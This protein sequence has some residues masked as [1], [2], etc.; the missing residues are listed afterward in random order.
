MVKL[1]NLFDFDER[2]GRKTTY[3]VMFLLTT[4]L[5]AAYVEGQ[6]CSLSAMKEHALNACDNLARKI[7]SPDSHEWNPAVYTYKVHNETENKRRRRTLS[8]MWKVPYPETKGYIRMNLSHRLYHYL[9]HRIPHVKTNEVE[10]TFDVALL[11]KFSREHRRH[12]HGHSHEV[13]SKRSDLNALVTY[14]CYM[15]EDDDCND[16][17][18]FV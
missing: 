10:D 17:L 18:C 15:P 6:L 8:H 7:R 1:I 2:G 14:C 16:H 13:R 5:M 9:S 11:G 12:R 3:S 4:T